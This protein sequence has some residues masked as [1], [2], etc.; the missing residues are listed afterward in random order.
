MFLRTLLF[1][2]SKLNHYQLLG[3]KET[4]TKEE[5]KLKFH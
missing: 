3:L 5:I 1:R 4:A 2:F